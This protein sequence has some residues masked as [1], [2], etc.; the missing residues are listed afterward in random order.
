MSDS[1]PFNIPASIFEKL[2]KK[3]EEFTKSHF[4]NPGPKIA[5][6]IL[7][8]MAEGVTLGLELARDIKPVW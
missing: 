7:N 3:A 6:I 5:G 8:A 1:N 4:T 2:E